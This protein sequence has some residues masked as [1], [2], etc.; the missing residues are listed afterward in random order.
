MAPFWAQQ[1]QQQPRHEL[2]YSGTPLQS[3]R[4]INTNAEQLAADG[5]RQLRADTK[6]ELK[7]GPQFTPG[8]YMTP[9]KR[10]ING[11]F[12]GEELPR[13]C[14]RVREIRGVVPGGM[15][16]VGPKYDVVHAPDKYVLETAPYRKNYLAY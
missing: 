6:L 2:P 11:G 9:A 7:G 13:R 5:K 1:L 8:A 14:F 16:H 10:H 15:Q 4:V 3:Q 12:V